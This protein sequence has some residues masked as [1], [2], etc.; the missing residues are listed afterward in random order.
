MWLN[1]TN[2]IVVK[3]YHTFCQQIGTFK[4]YIIMRYVRVSNRCD[5]S[6]S[7]VVLTHPLFVLS[8]THLSLDSRDKEALMSHRKSEEQRMD[9]QLKESKK[10]VIMAGGLFSKVPWRVSTP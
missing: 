9:G 8:L 10:N 3:Y 6:V 2:N 7:I 5:T 4:V 1:T